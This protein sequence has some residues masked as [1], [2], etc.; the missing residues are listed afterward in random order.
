ML[1]HYPMIAL[2]L[3]FGSCSEMPMAGPD[4]SCPCS[5]P[6][7][8]QVSYGNTTSHLAATNVQAALDELA[9]KPVEMPIGPRIVRVQQMTANNHLAQLSASAACPDEN[10]DIALG[11]DCVLGTDPNIHI[12]QTNINNDATHARYGCLFTQPTTNAEPAV[13]GVLCLRGA[14]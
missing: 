6:T 5:T 4:A 13:I 9:A 3:T 14:R 12:S 2:F 11:G 8:A 1:R 7:A 10:H